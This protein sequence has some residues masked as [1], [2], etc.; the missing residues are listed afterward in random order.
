MQSYRNRWTPS[1][2]YNAKCNK[3]ITELKRR[4]RKAGLK[5]RRGDTYP[6]MVNGTY[7]SMRITRVYRDSDKEDLVQIKYGDRIGI[8]RREKADG[9]FDYTALV[10]WLK[11]QEVKHAEQEKLDAKRNAQVTATVSVLRE[12]GLDVNASSYYPNTYIGE[13]AR[14]NVA[15]DGSV[16]FSIHVP[17]DD[18]YGI[19]QIVT[20]CKRIEVSRINRTALNC[21]ED[22][23]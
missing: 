20:M 15:S 5:L 3:I 1:P 17:H 12:E 4:L 11:D 7:Y 22:Q 18:P 23:R 2:G 21:Q 8:M 19:R 6:N 14:L 16:H 10:E 13:Y 9:S